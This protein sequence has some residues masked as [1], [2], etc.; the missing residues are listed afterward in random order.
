MAGL[1]ATK[2]KSLSNGDSAHM[3]RLQGLGVAG[4]RDLHRAASHVR[5]ELLSR[6][7]CD[8]HQIRVSSYGRVA[9]MPLGNR[10]SSLQR[11]QCA[12]NFS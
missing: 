6:H 4:L 1:G 11:S 12:W 3:G 8:M 10:L 7:R 5:Q 9:G 2:V